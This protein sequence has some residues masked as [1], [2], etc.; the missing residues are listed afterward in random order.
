MT[1]PSFWSII[2]PNIN[3]YTIVGLLMVLLSAVY[4]IFYKSYLKFKGGV[5][6]IFDFGIVDKLM[7]GIF[8]FGLVISFGFS[9]IEDLFA[10]PLWGVIL[11]GGVVIVFL[12]ILIYLPGKDGKP[13]MFD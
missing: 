7:T 8:I 2:L 1:L 13:G 3:S 9:F 10:N 11:T 5:G 6:S 4:F 12:L